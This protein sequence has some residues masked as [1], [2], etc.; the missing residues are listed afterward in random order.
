MILALNRHLPTLLLACAVSLALADEQPLPDPLSLADALALA[1]D[2][3]PALELAGAA[4]DASAAAL[5]EAQSLT[6]L[7]LDAVGRLR[8]IEPSSI[9]LNRDPN[10]SSARLALTKRL[11]DFGYS[12]AREQAARLAGDGNEWRYLD[13]RQQAHQQ[14]MR[15]FFD[16]ILADLQYARDNEA[17]AGAYIAADR[18]RDRHELK[19]LSDVDLLQL[20]AEYQVALRNRAQSQTLQRAARS[21]LAIAMGRPSELAPNVVRPKAPDTTVPLPDYETLLAEV[22]QNNPGL[23]AL[24]A[25]VDAARAEVQA[26]R[27]GHGPVI[28]A[29]LEAQTFNRETNTTNPLGATLIF[30]VPLLT[31]GAKDAEIAKAGARLRS[32]SATLAASEQTLR[33][34]VLDL[35]LQLDNL[36]TQLAGLKVRGDY[37]EL[38]LDRSRALYE[39][40]VKADLGDAMTEISA[41][42]LDVAQ[43]EFDWMMTQARLAALAGR[44]LPEEQTQ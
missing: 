39:M 38:Y 2:D 5:A 3:L 8:A 15:S 24:R 26:A 28:S 27:N 33:Q 1:R 12:A 19:R 9:A 37:R 17:M 31:G 34:Q 23:K 40:E 7:R 20:E 21:R 18:A 13:A 35:W 36:R 29:E 42:R 11:Y 25:E 6:G 14:I 44:L 4:R 22:L 32:V 10:D 30:E 43:A 41:L 16:V